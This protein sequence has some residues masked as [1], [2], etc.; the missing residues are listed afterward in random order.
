[1]EPALHVNVC[2]ILKCPLCSV[3]YTDPDGKEVYGKCKRDCKESDDTA[4]FGAA[5]E[6]IE[7]DEAQKDHDH[8][9]PLGKGVCPINLEK[10]SR[11]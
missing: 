5:G 4:K 9:P 10:Q 8:H 6:L 2:L 11:S 1:M 7:E 3:P